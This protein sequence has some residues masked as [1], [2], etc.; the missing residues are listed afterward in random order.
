MKVLFCTDGSSKSFNA[1]DNFSKWFNNF[2]ADIVSVSDMAYFTD[3][4]LVS[5]GKILE[6]CSNNVNNILNYSQDYFAQKGI[7]QGKLIKMCGSAVDNIL[8]LDESGD[9]KYIILGSNAKKGI[10]KWLGSVSQEVASK[11]KTSVYISKN[12]Q[13]LKKILFPLDYA[14]LQNSYFKRNISNMNLVDSKISLMSIYQMPDFLF[15]EGNIDSNWISD[16]EQK[17]QRES[18]NIINSVEKLFIQEG[19]SIYDKLVTK[20]NPSEVIIEYIKNNSQ[21]LVAME[22]SK[23]KNRVLNNSV[24]RLVLEHS[25][26]DVLIN[27]NI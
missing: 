1:I 16:V 23:N 8:E 18:V 9:Y 14:L 25:E 20:G 21:S 6:K 11:S 3:E 10:Q 26:S 19:L 15:L 5:N 24:I 12:E 13:V 17:Q 7:K 2:E 22:I 4:M 27:K